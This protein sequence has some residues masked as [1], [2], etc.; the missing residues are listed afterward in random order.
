MKLVILPLAAL[1][2]LV[3]GPSLAA[4]ADETSGGLRIAAAS[5]T[6][7][8]ADRARYEARTDEA[9][10]KTGRRIETLDD[11]RRAL[12]EYE[13]LDEAWAAIKGDWA[14]TKAM[15]GEDWRQGAAQFERDYQALKRQVKRL[16]VE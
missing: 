14:R 7:K 6:T 8:S 16:A 15:F 9:L 12:P 5:E 10:A 1:S 3:A 13:R 11:H 2:L 4:V